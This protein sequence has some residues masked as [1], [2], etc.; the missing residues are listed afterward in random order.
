MR[1][2]ETNHL[3]KIANE[4]GKKMRGTR[5]HQR[6][7]RKPGDLDVCKCARLRYEHEG[8]GLLPDHDF[9]PIGAATERMH[10]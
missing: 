9:V 5:R 10:E 6:I 1:F 2:R 8:S 7:T 4:S 3:R